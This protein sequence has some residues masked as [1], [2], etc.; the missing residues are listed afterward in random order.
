MNLRDEI[1]EF[2]GKY[3]P[4]MS[5]KVL[6]IYQTLENNFK[7]GFP[8]IYKKIKMPEFPEVLQIQ[9]HSFCNGSCITCPYPETKKEVEHG[10]MSEELFEKIIDEASEHDISRI[11]PSLMNEPLLDDRL[12]SFIDYINKKVPEDYI[13]FATNGKALKEGMA[14]RLAKVR[15]NHINFSLHG[16]K[17]R[18]KEVMGFEI[19]EVLENIEY[20]LSLDKKKEPLISA[21]CFK[22][23]MNEK[24]LEDFVK[25]CQNLGIVPAIWDEMHDRAG[26]IKRDFIEDTKKKEKVR[27]CQKDRQLKWFHI[28]YNGDVILCC[29][30]WR[31]EI[32]L[33]NIKNKSIENIWQSEKYE[34]I[35]EKVEGSKKSQDNFLCKRC[36]YGL[37]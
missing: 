9:T 20:Y 29:Q 11:T 26:N 8:K 12:P 17:R 3:F 2:G 24:E 25:Y 23:F 7:K 32:K 16:W 5:P 6:S 35:R 28:L 36:E 37:L 22:E 19:D 15:I 1:K 4:G 30:D 21:S 34:K 31:Q 13:R 14:E 18:H 10:R 27:G 33:G